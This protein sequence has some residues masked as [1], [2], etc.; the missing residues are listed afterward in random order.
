VSIAPR[1]EPEVSEILG[2]REEGEALEGPTIVQP[3]GWAAPKGYS[4]GAV[5]TGKIVTVAG[6]VGW[7]P[8]TCVFEADDFAGQ[9]RQALHNLVAVLLAAGARPHDLVRLTCYVVKRG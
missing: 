7:N 1:D 5:A 3:E 4:N 9:V 6:Q 8:E 2:L